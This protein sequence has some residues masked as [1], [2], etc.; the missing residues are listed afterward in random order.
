MPY[1]GKSPSFGVRNRF[2]YLASSGATSVSGADANGATLTFTDG[3]YV[4]VYLNGVLLKPTTDY[5]TST[6]NTI[7]GLSALNTNDEVT[8]VVYDVFTV[9]DMVS[10]TSGGTFSGNVT[11][12]GTVTNSSTTTLNDDVTFTG[13][14]YNVMWDKSANDLSFDDN[15]KLT[16]GASNDLSVYHDGSNTYIDESGTGALFIRSSR[17]SMHKYTGETMINAAAD[18]AVSLYYDDVKKL[19]TTSSSVEIYQ[20]NLEINRSSESST[21]AVLYFNGNGVDWSLGTDASESG[22][23]KFSNNATPGTSTAMVFGPSQRIGF[24]DSGQTNVHVSINKAVSGSTLKVTN[25]TDDYGANN[26]WSVLGDNTND[27]GC[28]LYAGYSANG[29]RMFVNGNG[30]FHSATGT[31]ATISSDERLKSDIKDANSQWDD[32]KQ[33]KFKN[34]K[35]HDTDGLV[36]LGVIAQEA[37]KI[38]P[39][40]VIERNPLDTEVAHNSEFGTL[41][42]KDDVETQDVLYTKDDQDVKDG[43][44]N[45]GDVKTEASKNIGDV[46]EVKSKVKVFK[47]SILFWKTAKALQEAM[48]RI[49]TLEAKV[50]TLEE[51]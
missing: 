35:K 40:L 31:Y 3:A 38:C 10:A 36:H 28:N 5:N 8:V 27:D 44:A 26:I 17:V 4:D 19:E 42:T 24:G 48:T 21:D 16:F 20:A 23:L 50:K 29:H 34:F 6:A 14:N 22:Y 45:V 9:A 12:D 30:S 18:G 47:D 37:E 25:G 1:I 7:A 49:E 11:F 39:K 46:K 33:L 2:V 13:A 51:A 15:A 32:I 41:Y 43:K